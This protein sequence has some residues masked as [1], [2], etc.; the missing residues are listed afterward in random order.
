MKTKIP[1]ESL[2]VFG[3]LALLVLFVGGTAAGRVL[4][5]PLPPTL[6][7]LGLVLL[8]LRVGVVF[9][10]AEEAPEPAEHPA[11]GSLEPSLR[12]ANG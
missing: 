8:A 12:A 7:G 4:G 9:A 6:V 1:S 10:A 2:H 11:A 5:L 3:P